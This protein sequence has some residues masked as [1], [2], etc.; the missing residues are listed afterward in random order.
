MA[1]AKKSSSYRRQHKRSVAE[2]SEAFDLVGDRYCAELVRHYTP[3]LYQ[4]VEDGDEDGAEAILI[5]MENMV[6]RAVRALAGPIRI[7]PAREAK[8]R[9]NLRE[10]RRQV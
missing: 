9:R 4:A 1:A 5:R 3:L 7:S 2:F 8:I 10:H 6:E